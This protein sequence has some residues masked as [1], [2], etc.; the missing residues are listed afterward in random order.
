MTETPLSLTEL[1]ADIEDTLDAR[2]GGDV[3]WIT[4]EICDVKKQPE[5]RWCFLKFTEREERTVV[6]EMKAVCWA[7]GYDSIERFERVTRTP[8]ASGQVITCCVR[9]RFHARYGL[10]LEVLDIDVSQALEAA[11]SER[12]KT[13]ARLVKENPRLI[14]VSDGIYHTA[15]RQLPLPVVLQ[16]IALVTAPNSDGQRDFRKEL[17]H[18]PFQYKF[19]VTEF[20]TQ[21]QGDQSS[22][23]ILRQLQQIAGRR[24]EFD[25]VAIVRGGGSENDFKPFEDYDLSLAVA[26]F[27]IP[28]LTGIGHD[29]N[30]SIVDMMARQHKTP[31]KVA[32]SII[33][34]NFRFER[35]L[36]DA[37]ER[38]TVKVQNRIQQA[39]NNLEHFRRTIKAYSPETIIR[40]G[41]AVVMKGGT[42]IVD[43]AQISAGD[44]ITT[45]LR[46]GEL[47]SKV[48]TSNKAQ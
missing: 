18:N 33:D 19:T 16:R 25:V 23:L 13:L 32:G 12:E 46:E 11:V 8:F 6:A 44:E 29:R 40:K 17:E 21:I 20:L 10:D 14:R 26:S 2:F 3:F 27:P 15:N 22:T 48:I 30:T 43:S 28:V 38:I 47:V 24:G 35:E 37:R 36:L 1:L 39:K 42:I 7:V 4:A 5:K 45:V 34:H 31:T 41:Y 9:L